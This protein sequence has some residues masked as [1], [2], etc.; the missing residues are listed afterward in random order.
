[1]NEKRKHLWPSVAAYRMN[2]C[3][4]AVCVWL[5]KTNEVLEQ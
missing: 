4:C 5:R 3:D 1:M 2:D